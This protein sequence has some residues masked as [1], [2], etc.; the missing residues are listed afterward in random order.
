MMQLSK[1]GDYKS[2]NNDNLLAKIKV[3]NKNLSDNYGRKITI[4][5]KVLDELYRII[6]FCLEKENK[7]ALLEAA[8][9]LKLAYGLA[10][11]GK[12]IRPDEY[13]Y[14]REIAFAAL[15]ANEF[16]A[17]EYLVESSRNLLKIFSEARTAIID[18][19]KMLA[20][21]AMQKKKFFIASAVIE[22]LLYRLPRL[23]RE[24]SKTKAAVINC[25]S[26]FGLNALKNEEK[27]FFKELCA[28]LCQHIKAISETEEEHWEK[29]LLNWLNIC[30]KQNAQAAFA[31]WQKFFY[32]YSYLHSGA[33][34]AFYSEL[35]ELTASF[36]LSCDGKMLKISFKSI[37][38]CFWRRAN[39]LESML[40]VQ[41]FNKVFQNAASTLDWNETMFIFKPVFLFFFHL[42]N[43][44]EKKDRWTALNLS[45][46]GVF[47]QGINQTAAFVQIKFDCSE[48]I[49]VLQSWR[50]NFLFIGK[51]KSSTK[52]IKKFWRLS[53][54]Q[55]KK[56]NVGKVALN[57][58]LLAN[59]YE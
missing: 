36:I 7:A 58:D 44:L 21:M 16:Q 55:W 27:A 20:T 39:Y 31:D 29:L 8:E 41:A 13:L 49:T 54:E 53:A 18:T 9:S 47:L 45:L 56:D 15:A 23:E 2:F 50:T 24:D 22:I 38:K 25:F 32:K 33:N 40:C 46:L 57:N 59:F 11:E 37:L 17:V 19:L 4:T 3:L 30:L 34:P 26:G 48:S 14:W 35:V 5:N 12:Q 42:A 51:S 6:L 52:R 1:I 28:L 10:W 43:R